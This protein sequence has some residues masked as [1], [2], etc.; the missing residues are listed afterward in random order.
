VE[1]QNLSKKILILDV[2]AIAYRSYFPLRMMATTGGIPTGAIYGFLKTYRKMLKDVNP[3]YVIAA[4]DLKARLKRKDVYENYKSGRK[5]TPEELLDQLATIKTMMKYLNVPYLTSEGYEA[6]DVI[7]TLVTNVLDKDYEKFIVTGD[8]DL[9]QLINEENSVTAL[10]LR[11]DNVIKI[12]NHE[13]VYNYI[14]VTPEVIPDL[15]GLMG[16][17]SDGIPGVKGVGVKTA[18]KLLSEYGTL[19]NIYKNVNCLKGKLK[20][21]MQAGYQDA[22]ISRQLTYLYSNI[23]LKLDLKDAEVT[24]PKQEFFTLIQQLQFNSIIKEYKKENG[25]DY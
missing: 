23:D 12:S 20:E 9:L 6:D 15:F 22:F 19:E 11:K 14:G 13:E 8:K 5:E 18:L 25:G 24:E 21:K 2:N 10:L 16:D 17:A 3:D 1:V 7:A 4:S